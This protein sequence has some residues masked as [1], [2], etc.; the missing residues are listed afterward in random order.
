MRRGLWEALSHL[1]DTPP[2]TPALSGPEPAAPWSRNTSTV[3]RTL[4]AQMN[5]WL[6]T[7]VLV[8]YLV[9]MSVGMLSTHM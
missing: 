3:D 5:P 1:A 9:K 6:Q 7:L 4:L 2:E 8:V